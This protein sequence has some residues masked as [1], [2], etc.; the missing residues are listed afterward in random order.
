MTYEHWRKRLIKSSQT[1]VESGL[2]SKTIELS[3]KKLAGL[4]CGGQHCIKYE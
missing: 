4:H 1:Y 3:V 2:Y